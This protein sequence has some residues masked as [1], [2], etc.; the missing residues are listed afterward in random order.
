MIRL[1]TLGLLLVAAQTTVAWGHPGR[2]DATGCHTVHSRFVYKHSGK[3]AEVGEY[4]CHRKMGEMRFDGLEVLQD[5]SD[6]IPPVAPPVPCWPAD[7]PP[8][9]QWTLHKAEMREEAGHTWLGAHYK[10][11]SGQMLSA[12]WLDGEVVAIDPAPEGATPMWIQAG[13]VEIRDGGR[14]RMRRVDPPGPCRWETW[15]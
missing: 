13:R 1:V 4:H 6:S 2:L 12:V 14:H 3:V 7:V 15:P 9:N 8:V 5:A 11:P 10:L